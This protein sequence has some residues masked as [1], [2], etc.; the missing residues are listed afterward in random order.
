M[1]LN[2]WGFV[3]YGNMLSVMNGNLWFPAAL[4]HVFKVTHS[5][6]ILKP[7]AHF[8]SLDAGLFVGNAL[9][10]NQ[11]HQHCKHLRESNSPLLSNW[12]TH[13]C[14]SLMACDQLTASFLWFLTYE[15]CSV[16]PSVNW[17]LLQFINL[18]RWMA[19][20]WIRGP[21]MGLPL[22]LSCENHIKGTLSSLSN[23]DIL[24]FVDSL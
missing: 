23:C 6:L 8:S 21:F 1:F 17:E 16:F 3:V 4:L 5:L 22:C 10:F 9:N 2:T 24:M 13:Q 19:I 14:I 20:S 11:F 18:L 12:K 7:W 15:S